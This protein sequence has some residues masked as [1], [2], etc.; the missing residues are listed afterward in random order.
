MHL[1]VPSPPNLGLKRSSVLFY[2]NFPN[3]CHEIQPQLYAR[4]I[5][6][7]LPAFLPPRVY[8]NALRFGASSEPRRT[9]QLRRVWGDTHVSVWVA[10][11]EVCRVQ[12]RDLHRGARERERQPER[13]RLVAL[14]G[15]RK[16]AHHRRSFWESRKQH[17]SG[18]G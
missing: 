2:H 16:P 12:L 17:G 14:G 15:Y 6:S 4:L 13:F 10:V 11:S 3:L 1:R 8:V 5:S 18:R 9:L 7:T